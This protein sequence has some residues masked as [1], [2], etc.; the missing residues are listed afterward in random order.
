MKTF[1]LFFYYKNSLF[2]RTYTIHAILSGL[3]N[4]DSIQWDYSIKCYHV[5]HIQE[6]TKKHNTMELF[7]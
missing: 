7:K 2:I 3:S 5:F 6:A 1:E 4:Q